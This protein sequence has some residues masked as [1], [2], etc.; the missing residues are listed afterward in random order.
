MQPGEQLDQAGHVEHVAQALAV[1]LEDH[2]EVAVLLGHLEQRLGLQALLPQRGALA[3]PRA[4]DEQRAA[5]VLAEAG[6]EQG[7]RA[8]LGDDQVLDLVGLEQHEVGARRLLGVGQVDD[9]PVVGVDRVGLEADLVADA[10]AEGQRPRGVHAAAERG[11]DAQPPVADLVAEALDDDRPVGRDHPGGLLLLG[12]ELEQVAGR[13]L[14]EVVVALEHLR[15]LVDRPPRERAD[16]LAELLGASERV[17]LPERHRAGKAGRRGDDHPV[18]A[19]L[20][21]APRRRAEQERLAGAGL[22]DH[23]LVELADA[24]PVGQGDG[25][26]AAVGDRAGVGD[27]QLAGARPGA[28]RAGDPVPHDPRAQ[29]G[30]LLGGIAAVEHVEHV[31]ELRAGQLGVGVGA[32]DEREQVI[33]VDGCS[34]SCSAAAAMA[35]ICWASTSSALRGHDRRLDLGLAHPPGDDRALEQVGAELGEDPPAADVADG[36]PGA[37]DPLQAAGHR[38]GRLDLDDE[39]DGAHVDAELEAGGGHQ[40]RQLAGLEHLLDDRALLAGERAVVRA[41]DLLPRRGR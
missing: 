27:R 13:A 21:D 9:D 40:A 7:A 20:L 11:E 39:V 36:V 12:E 6:A 10:G 30:E 38:L 19:D 5:G 34:A 22:V 24:A 1:G 16:R 32:G 35:T 2:R 8:Q 37:A 26:E 4:G 33:D 17:A 31:L 3:G 14:V 23:L 29:L 25:V 15:R 18:A 41:G 28:D